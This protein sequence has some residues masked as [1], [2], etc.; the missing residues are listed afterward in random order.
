MRAKGVF[1]EV[2]ESSLYQTRTVQSDKWSTKR[3]KE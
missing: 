3:V 1:Y 2:Q